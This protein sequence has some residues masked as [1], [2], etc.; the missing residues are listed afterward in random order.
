MTDVW[1]TACTE[2]LL[3][4]LW[5]VN[6]QALWLLPVALLVTHRF[7]RILHPKLLSMLWI[8]LAVQML[9]PLTW[10]TPWSLGAVVHAHTDALAGQARSWVAAS[11][12]V[13]WQLVL[14]IWCAGVVTLWLQL[15][16]RARM[17]HRW[18]EHLHHD[19]A[20]LSQLAQRLQRCMQRVGL[21][22]APRIR[23]VHAAV[24][25]HVFGLGR[26]TLVLPID[27]LQ[28]WDRDTLDAVLMHELMHLKRRDTWLQWA[29]EMLCALHWFNPLVRWLAVRAHSSREVC[30]DL[31]VMNLWRSNNRVYRRVLLQQALNE[32][33][34]QPP[35]ST[36]AVAAGP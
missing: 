3:S 16:H 18:V 26:G 20:P 7:E 34:N 31:D 1:M 22:R 2:A 29:H 11:G 15:W 8:L 36:G 35:V 14:A 30:C 10:T 25:P 9:V 21:H 33:E 27:A 24:S 4:W 19:G 5:R 13:A 6:S 17:H 12:A 32:T 23:C 28:G